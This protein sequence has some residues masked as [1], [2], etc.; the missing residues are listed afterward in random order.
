MVA[1]A[2]DARR[3]PLDA[4]ALEPGGECGVSGATSVRLVLY[5]LWGDVDT[6]GLFNRFTMNL[7]DW[8]IAL[9]L[10]LALAVPFWLAKLRWWVGLLGV[11]AAYE[12]L[13]VL[14]SGKS[15]SQHFW[16]FSLSHPAWQVYGLV[17]LLA[18]AWALLC[19]HLLWKRGKR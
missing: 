5:L 9:P 14:A 10:L 17:W 7:P 8:V 11:I 12:G 15:L 4:L 19:W 16:A 6:N 2:Y 13:T 1:P 3:V 18:A